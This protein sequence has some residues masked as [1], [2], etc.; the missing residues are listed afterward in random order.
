MFPLMGR[1]PAQTV[2]DIPAKSG[3][4]IQLTTSIENTE[5]SMRPQ[6]GYQS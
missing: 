3:E 4:H 5:H 6:V 1:N 2:F